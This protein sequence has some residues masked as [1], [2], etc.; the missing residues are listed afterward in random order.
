M[1]IRAVKNIQCCLWIILFSLLMS[2]NRNEDS[3]DV[4]VENTTLSIQGIV[5]DGF[6]IGAT[7]TT[8]NTEGNLIDSTVTNE[9]GEYEFQDLLEIPRFLN[10]EGGTD[11]GADITSPKDDSQFMDNLFAVYSGTTTHIT[12]LTTLQ[13]F[14]TIELG[15][16]N[17]FTGEDFEDIAVVVNVIRILRALGLTSEQAYR[18]VALSLE[19]SS[20]SRAQRLSD[21]FEFLDTAV[22]TVTEGTFALSVSMNEVI[23]TTVE[24]VAQV[25][26]EAKKQESEP[27]T[28]Q[29]Q[30]MQVINGVVARQ[31]ELS[32][33]ST[34]DVSG[35][36]S[37][38]SVKTLADFIIDDPEETE[39]DTLVDV[40][41]ERIEDGTL[42]PDVA[43][44]SNLLTVI[45][46]QN[47]TTTAPTTTSLSTT[48]IAE[49][50]VVTTTAPTTTL[51]CQ[52]ILGSHYSLDNQCFQARE[53]VG[54]RCA[55][56][57]FSCLT[58][59]Q[60][61]LDTEGNCWLFGGCIPEGWT[62][63]ETGSTC[64]EAIDSYCE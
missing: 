4:I 27:T 10:T 36:T 30:A 33:D 22:E 54:Q 14:S 19:S 21:K 9:A 3:N 49:T 41:G 5:F 46:A 61:L 64:A 42:E 26:E 32:A 55:L 6:V 28:E 1:S 18:S 23:D 58:A 2:C 51:Y 47:T 12:P 15:L 31:I 24:M 7:V 13:Y 48:T 62:Y 11:S 17:G 8:Y 43:L 34:P 59:L 16:G 35:L 56:E 53:I 50:T 57:P 63:P 25:F 38:E 39:V 20:I 29:L 40:L 45:I 37:L 60:K 44:E 52:D